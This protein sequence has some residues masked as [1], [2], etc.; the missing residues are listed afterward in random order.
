[1]MDKNYEK[2]EF[3]LGSTIEEA[4]NK[5]LNYRDIGELVCGEFNGVILYSDTV[6]MDSAYRKITGKS[7]AE[8]DEYIRRL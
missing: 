1:M 7:K 6:T 2:I 4:V 5:L 8:F 3:I